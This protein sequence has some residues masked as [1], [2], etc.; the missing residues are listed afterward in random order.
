MHR[1]MEPMPGAI[2]ENAGAGGEACWNIASQRIVLR[3]CGAVRPL[4]TAVG[5][6][7]SG[8]FEK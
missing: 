3:A 6:D 5:N 8:S 2:G 1:T 7:S 4:I